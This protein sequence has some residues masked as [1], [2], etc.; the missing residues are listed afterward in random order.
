MAVR[1]AINGF[2]RIGRLV[3][4]SALS[5]PAIEFVAVNDL[6]DPGTLSFLFCHDSVHGCLPEK[7]QVET[8]ENGIKIGGRLIK[9]LGERDPEKLPWKELGVDAVL[10][11]TGLFRSREGASK[12][13]EAGAGHV[14][15]SAP[16][17]NPDI[18]VVM[19][20]NHQQ[21]DRERD[22]I[23]SNA[24]CTTNCLAP[25]A[26]VLDEN[27]KIVHGVMTTIHSYTSDQR[28][29]DTPHPDLRRARAA[30]LSMIP[31]TTGAASAVGEVLP[32]LK[33]KL[34]GLAVRV[35]TPNVSLVDLTVEVGTRTDAESINREM[36]KASEEGPLAG[37]LKY[38]DEPL[39]S[40]DFNGDQ[41]SSIF[42]APMTKVVDGT[43]AKVLSW[44]DNEYGYAVRL[45]DLVKY[46]YGV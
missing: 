29:L 18:T 30:A 10:E 26:K 17:K 21:L 5:D 7:D 43:M 14:I 13:L 3:L 4:R 31:T 41:A 16:G 27:F 28:L 32:Q 35:P 23:I 42:D 8:T 12:H 39:V 33:G 11:C 6:T 36:K 44:Y 22:R 20:V 45:V 38:N 1:V 9:V 46:L 34:D 19:G 2:G 15:I 25:I 24:S 37:Y 40:S